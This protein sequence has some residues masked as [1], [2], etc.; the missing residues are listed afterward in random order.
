MIGIVTPLKVNNYG[1]KLQAY[2]VQ[3][4]LSQLGFN[5]EIIIYNSRKD[6]RARIVIK[7]LFSPQ[8][9]KG[10]IDSMRNRANLKSYRIDELTSKRNRAINSLDNRLYSLTPEISGYNNLKKYTQ[11]H[12][13]IICG[14]D[15]VWNP[16]AIEAGF[17]SVEFISGIPKIAFSPSF[18]VSSIP[19]KM[20]RRYKRFLNDFTALSSRE[21]RG[22]Q[23]IREITGRVV[24]VTADPTLTLDKETWEEF[25]SYSN[26]VIPSFPY[27]FCYLLGDNAEHRK[28]I[29]KLSEI[30]GYKV[31]SLPHFKGYAKSDKGFAD[32]E[33]Y[34]VNPA[35]FVL[36]IANAQFICTDS[37][38][39]TVFSIIFHKQFFVFERYSAD[40]VKSTNNRIQSLL[41]L[42]DSEDRI[43]KEC[44]EIEGKYNNTI[45]YTA[46]DQR[47][48]LIRRETDQYL[49]HA[50]VRIK[51]R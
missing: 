24:K 4:K 15:Q 39:G 16:E 5:S 10:R 23:I 6:T 13:A 28:A 1:T 45:D 27:I 47:L 26:L 50:M 8:K 2:A 34:E 46:V 31:V 29:K 12:S 44:L 41:S 14:S 36:L 21:A 42:L 25:C 11:K 40:D 32:V 3:K 18:G 51:E 38:H 19:P 48:S 49:Q 37:F 17:T 30:T 22:A 7:K 20:M 35:D 33:L 43:I 9:I